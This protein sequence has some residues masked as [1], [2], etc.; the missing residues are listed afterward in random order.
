MPIAHAH[1]AHLQN[2]TLERPALEGLRC[3]E[4]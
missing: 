1:V 3:I 4:G 2:K